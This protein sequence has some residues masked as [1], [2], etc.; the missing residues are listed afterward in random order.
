MPGLSFDDYVGL[1]AVGLAQL[2]R[3]RKVSAAEALDAAIARADAVNPRI[4][5]IVER[6]DDR[7]RAAAAAGLSGPLAGVPWAVKDLGHDIAGVR[8]TSGSRG[9]KDY[10]P[11]TDSESVRRMRAAGLNIVCTTTSPE[12]GLTVTTESTLHGQTR[13]P[14]NL[15]RTSGGSSGG[16]SALVAAGVVPAAHATD[17]GGSIRVPAACC[18]LFGLK[19]SR[20][21]TPV[22]VG[23]TEGWNGLGVSHAVTR[24]VRD[25]AAILDA[26]HGPEPGS[27][28]VAPPPA[29]TFLAAAGRPPG[30]ALRIALQLAPSSGVAVDPACI[31]AARDAA[32]LCEDLGHD[33]EEAAPALDFDAL[34]RAMTMV[35]SSHTA[36]AFA[37]RGVALGR[38]MTAA[39]MELAT[40]GFV[41]LGQTATALDM[42]AADQAFMTAAIAVARF[43]ETYDLILTPVLAKPPVKLG[44]VALNQTL[45]A[46][47]SAFSAFCPFTALANQ[48]GQ[49]AMSVPLFWSDGLPIG[50]QFAARLGE[51]E[52]LFSL[53][54]QL[55]QARPWFDKRAAL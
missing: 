33:V 53:A 28:Y 22:A 48:T 43:Q 34:S 39:D 54:H 49:P 46:Y 10:V 4:N 3:A 51:E 12:F 40:G 21:R 13:N 18:G 41:H 44:E 38:A 6:L 27:R 37:A 47:G 16:A 25:S 50:V 31:T 20:G 26:L 14:W 19:P 23:R 36:A 24:S 17:G 8:L 9:F 29:G 7:A 52:L 35:T 5:A 55:E 32:K 30:R 45:Q 2:I 11:R 42:V 1:D 15:E